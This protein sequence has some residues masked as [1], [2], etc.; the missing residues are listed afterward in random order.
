MNG[1]SYYYIVIPKGSDDACFGP[2]SEC[3][4]AAPLDGPAFQFTCESNLAVLN[5]Q[6]TPITTT[7]Q[8]TVFSVSN[9]TGTISLSCDASAMEDVDCT[10]PS[11]VAFSSGDEYQDVPVT[12]DA[13]LSTP[14]GQETLILIASD[15][16]TER[17]SEVSVVV[18]TPGGN[19]TASYDPI[20]RT[21]RC[22][23]SGSEC[24]SGDLLDG[25]GVDEANAPNVLLRE[26]NDGI[27]GEYHVHPS[28]D[29]I[30][31]KAGKLD[32]SGSGLDLTERSY[33]TVSATVWST[34]ATSCFADFYFTNNI[35]NPT[36]EYIGTQVTSKVRELEVLQMDYELPVGLEQAVR[37]NF[38]Y[39]GSA[40]TCPSGGYRNYGD[41]DDLVYTVKESAFYISCPDSLVVVD[42]GDAPV[43]ITKNC[44]LHTA[45]SFSGTISFSCDASAMTGTNC[46]APSD[47]SIESGGQEMH[48]SYVVEATD[49]VVGGEEEQILV[50]A[51]SSGT[52]K[53]S[54]FVMLVLSS[55]GSQK[56][57]YDPTLG[58]PRCFAE[59]SECVSGDLLDGR[60][61]VGPEPN[62]PNSLDTCTDGNSGDYRVDEQ[63]DAITVR[64]GRL[65]G[66][67]SGGDISEGEYITIAAT[68]F[69]YNTNDRADFWH[70]PD[71]YS[72]EWQYIGSIY[73]EETNATE[74]I[75]IEYKLPQG[76]TQA[77][78]V[79]YDYQG[80]I[81]TCR[82]T[83]YGDVDDIVFAVK[84]VPFYISCPTELLVFNIE[85]API[86]AEQ[87]CTIYSQS[88]FEG[89]LE[90]DCDSSGLSGVEC[91]SD[92][93]IDI[94][95]GTLET[96]ITVS[97]NISSSAIAGESGDILITATDPQANITK[98]SPIQVLIIEGGGPQ[99]AEYDSTL[100]APRCYA[101]GSSCS[102]GELLDG[103]GEM[104]PGEPNQPNTLDDC[105]D[106]S[107]GNYH[108]HPSI[109]VIEV[110]GKNG[111]VEI[112][113]YDAVTVS[114][115]VWATMPDDLSADFYYTSTPEDPDWIFIDTL[116]TSNSGEAEVLEVDYNLPS[117]TNQAVRVHFRYLGSVGTCPD[118]NYWNY[119]DADDLVFA[120][121]QASFSISCPDGTIRINKENTPES[122]DVDC[123]LSVS[124]NYNG[125]INLSCSS[126][127]LTG[128][129]CTTPTSVDILSGDT[130]VNVTVTL[131]AGN[132]VV[133]GEEGSVLV[134]ASDE[135]NSKTSAIGVSVVG[136]GGDQ[137][138]T[139]DLSYGT[140]FCDLTG[141]SCSSGDLL[142][143]RG[144]VTPEP[145]QPNTLDD[146]EDGAK[147]EHHSDESIDA[148]VVRSGRIDGESDDLIREGEYVTIVA[149]V[150]AYSPQDSG[151][152]FVATNPTDPSWQYIGSV[153]ATQEDAADE[154]VLETV[155][156][157]GLIQAVRVNFHYRTDE[158]ISPCLGGRYV[159][160]VML[161]CARRRL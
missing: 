140:P 11:S 82:E 50:Y 23:V 160:I 7:H 21:P 120:V 103:R 12:L 152:F 57:T 16:S 61:D 105:I 71:A 79:K 91:A 74:V 22:V 107:W 58:A 46:I 141:K 30:V 14:I 68:V 93:P 47:V 113:E 118:G 132:S 158:D 146:C 63:S 51:E 135:A 147:G 49:S 44:T 149:T 137:V 109:D 31:V 142:F 128:I 112:S 85:E 37:V 106:G 15:G 43:N 144:P 40:G 9:F 32:G 54:S 108:A 69:A 83:A 126:A 123:S 59:G 153:N 29:K 86:T 116:T 130:E 131:D 76:S 98:T 48:V 38:R 156:P 4:E 139:F 125:T 6:T 18:V 119:G 155:L 39:K 138:A 33:A 122:I 96:N 17:K 34:F 121:K 89:S 84:Y 56:A 25:K 129:N 151:D 20:I 124:S 102:S 99:T 19:Q 75:E 111:N 5:K 110:K 26:C 60:G 114:A 104:A 13:S 92:S 55:G 72:V 65:D 97:M 27:W 90:I 3:L 73:S 159:S 134:S 94:E 64:A 24:S 10:V 2:G 70:A 28:N 62:A 145:N 1:R 35:T 101:E 133:V 53:T 87:P 67:G 136:P 45:S 148:I 127:S 66:S 81:T 154:L 95:L 78:R 88:D 41:V 8:C 157:K 143:G 42:K 36:W 115:T 77:V 100:G 117:G 150:W 161:P 52:S 80:N